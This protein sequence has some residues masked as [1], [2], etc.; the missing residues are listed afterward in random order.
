MTFVCLASENEF[1]V[2]ITAANQEN[3][4]IYKTE[5]FGLDKQKLEFDSFDETISTG[6]H[7]VSI[8]S[9]GNVIRRFVELETAKNIIDELD[10]ND[11]IV[12]ELIPISCLHWS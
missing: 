6:K 4:I 12:I 2:L 1:Y 5:F 9:I 3:N 11:I 7:R 10:T 8:S